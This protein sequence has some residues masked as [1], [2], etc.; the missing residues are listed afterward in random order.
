[1]QKM[2][3]FVAVAAFFTAL[4]VGVPPALAED[5]HKIK[6]HPTPH[7]GW[8]TDLA[9]PPQRINSGQVKLPGATIELNAN[10][11]KVGSLWAID[12]AKGIPVNGASTPQEAAEKYLRDNHVAFGLSENLSELRLK[13]NVE[14]NGLARIAYEQT[15]EGY[16]VF[17]AIIGVNVQVPSMAIKVVDS[18]IRPIAEYK[19]F[20]AKTDSASA[21]K[22]AFDAVNS[23]VPT[24]TLS[25]SEF[26]TT[27]GVL[28][29][30]GV[31]SA[32]WEIRF[33][34]HSGSWIV[35]IDADTNAFLSARD[36]TK[37]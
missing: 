14:D 12:L 22:A 21:I 2:N 24:E 13:R 33:A 20:K 19:P 28:V 30:D 6:T 17:G 25:D 15:Y 27:L 9:A 32:A 5:G 29:Q 10:T 34:A 31:P 23:K 3:H 36:V 7:E 8:G 4:V 37:Y 1:M 11:K 35:L 18:T 16:P 26:Q